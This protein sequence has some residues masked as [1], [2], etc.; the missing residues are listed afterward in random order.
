MFENNL[1]KINSEFQKIHDFVKAENQA[2]EKK[3][4]EVLTKHLDDKVRVDEVQDA[5]KRITDGFNF[6]L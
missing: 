1:K 5:L 3:T 6:K 2:N 4:K